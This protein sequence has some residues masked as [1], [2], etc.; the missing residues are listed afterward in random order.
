LG[1]SGHVNN[2]NLNKTTTMITTELDN[3]TRKHSAFR[4]FDELL[5]AKGNYRPTIC[6]N[7]RGDYAGNL[8]RNA[9][10]M[11]YDDHQQM[12]GDERRAYRA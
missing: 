12:R 10:L 5:N 1:F 6:T 2:D 3:L 7:L 9:L 11:A 8:E 4:S